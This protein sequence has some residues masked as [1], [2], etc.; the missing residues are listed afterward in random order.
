LNHGFGIWYCIDPW[1]R[2]P[3]WGKNLYPDQ[4]SGKNIPDHISENLEQFLGLKILK[5]WD[6][7]WKN[8][9]AGSGINIPDPQTLMEHP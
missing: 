4:G 5:F 1:I 7:G 6:P 3:G 9:D 8:L 2:D